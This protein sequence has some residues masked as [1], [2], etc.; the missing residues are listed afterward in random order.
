[1]EQ[2]LNIKINGKELQVPY[3]TTVLEAA[4]MANINIPTLCYLKDINEIGACRLCLVEVK[5]ARG[6][7]AACVYPIERDGTEIVTESPAIR[8]NRKM[9][10]ELLLSNHNKKCL[11]CPRSTTC[12]LQQLCN[13]YGVDE[14]KF[15]GA[16]T[17]TKIDNSSLSII[18]DNSK[19]ILCRRCSATC[20][21]V[22]GIGVIGANNRG[23]DTVIGCTFDLPLAETSCI[24]CGQCV[25]ACPTG[26]LSE[27]DDTAKVF[28]AIADPTKH[29]AICMAPSVRAQ[30][31]E[32]FGYEPG[33][34]CEGKMVAAT[35]ALGFDGVYDMNLTADL[36][37]MEEATEFLSRVKN[38]GPLPLITS[39]SPGWIKYCEHYFPEMTENL[40]TCKSPQQM[41]G[42]L[43]K[44]Y[45][46]QKMGLNPEDIVFV[47][48]IPCT[49]KKFEV[50]RPD[51]S[52]A[53][54]PDV[55]IA[56]TTRE[57]GRMIK[58]AGIDFKAMDDEK[59][60]DPFDI[61]S[62]AGVIFGA[63]GGVMEAALR[64]AAEVIL[65]QP[66]EKLEFED[67]RGTEGIKLASYKLG[68][69]T[70]NVAVTSGTGNAKK[71]LKGV[72]S[73]EIK[74]DFI[75]VMAC[76]GGCVN[77]GGQ[78]Y[79]PAVVRNNVDLRA[80][81]ASVLYTADAK[82]D[83]RKSHENSAVKK[84]YDE[85]FGEPNSHKAHEI[86][87]TSYIKRGL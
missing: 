23:F 82:M 41:F 12:E 51:Q 57:L 70:V 86:L 33:T 81:R 80:L 49:A 68:D 72:Q 69:L 19:C 17:E 50:N 55:D 74:A 34:D 65:G 71:L 52:A 84:L 44:T 48:A 59:F 4:R 11:S 31:G 64:T 53:G 58:Q 14:D 26:A 45:Y 29:V 39:C 20:E 42:A 13:E 32:C 2:M 25:V 1:M 28:E 37:I 79:Q 35:K 87:H 6:L 36:T 61:G 67:V 3:G 63:T 24:N 5:G 60:D 85:Y 27:R 15:A 16:K 40:S 54:V 18:R 8:R 47:S 83:L 9:N 21:K 73:G 76:P 30:I 78:P 43:Y 10:L 56:I 77:G 75:E 22:Q 46:A 66:L 62:G 7:V 38:G